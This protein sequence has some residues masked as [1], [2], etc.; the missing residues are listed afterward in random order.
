MLQTSKDPVFTEVFGSSPERTPKKDRVDHRHGSGVPGGES[1][2]QGLVSRF[3][4][5]RGQQLQAEYDAQ[6]ANQLRIDMIPAPRITSYANSSLNSP[7][8]Y[9]QRSYSP[10][11]GG[12]PQRQGGFGLAGLS[13]NTSL[14]SAEFDDEMNFDGNQWSPKRHDRAATDTLQDAGDLP[15]A[16][17][18]AL[19]GSMSPTLLY[20]SKLARKKNRAAMRSADTDRGHR[21]VDEES[22]PPLRP[23]PRALDLFHGAAEYV[24]MSGAAT[25]R[26]LAAA[27][28]G[29]DSRSALDTAPSSPSMPTDAA[30]LRQL[31]Q[32][33]PAEVVNPSVH[34]QRGSFTSL[35]RG[36]GATDDS[37]GNLL[38]DALG[39]EQSGSRAAP[40]RSIG[41]QQR[42]AAQLAKAGGYYDFS[43]PELPADYAGTT[44]VPLLPNGDPLET[45]L[46]RGVQ[47][48]SRER[49]ASPV[50]ERGT[51]RSDKKVQFPLTYE[52]S[53]EI[54]PGVPSPETKY[55]GRLQRIRP[56]S[57]RLPPHHPPS[58]Q[59]APAS[60]AAALQRPQSAAARTGDRPP[61]RP[62]ASTRRVA[63]A[64]RRRAPPPVQAVMGAKALAAPRADKGARRWVDAQ[65]RREDADRARA[66]A[67][68]AVQASLTLAEAKAAAS[69]T[70]VRAGGDVEGTMYLLSILEDQDDEYEEELRRSGNWSPRAGDQRGAGGLHATGTA[71]ESESDLWQLRQ[72]LHAAHTSPPP[73]VHHSVSGGI[74]TR[75]QPLREAGGG[76]RK[77][78]GGGGGGGGDA[79]DSDG[80]DVGD[81]LRSVYLTHTDSYAAD[82]AGAVFSRNM[83][84]AEPRVRADAPPASRHEGGAARARPSSAASSKHSEQGAQ[85]GEGGGTQ[86]LRHRM[87]HL[88]RRAM[89]TALA[90]RDSGSESDEEQARESLPRLAASH[91]ASGAPPRVPVPAVSL[92]SRGGAR[93]KALSALLRPDRDLAAFVRSAEPGKAPAPRRRKVRPSSAAA[94]PRRPHGFGLGG[95]VPKPRAPGVKRGPAVRPASARQMRS[96]YG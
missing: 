62:A 89:L 40:P 54:L 25:R 11:E 69:A 32:Q 47:R 17:P 70:P 23:R 44:V 42:E 53:K 82:L 43:A 15:A 61:W 19:S 86:F 91:K 80:I 79:G 77:A 4:V 90:L 1:R 6:R 9:R 41:Q 94:S 26:M 76:V 8:N 7:T 2:P 13:I 49:A 3:G 35:Q 65:R 46:L 66:E 75:P 58:Q 33:L 88:Q 37:H 24:A 93:Q 50:A 85:G 87:R 16:V 83:K 30:G 36:G 38:A 34:I 84:Y 64:S 22:H 56:R 68:A 55:K 28:G 14:G 5:A 18:A 96:V 73:T 51:S 48:R 78:S 29:I 27:R 57:A 31:G 95:E 67:A 20:L 45:A 52:E 12:S 92:G 71:G 39:T 59:A 10:S 81:D 74:P 60:A 21:G 72:D 63:D